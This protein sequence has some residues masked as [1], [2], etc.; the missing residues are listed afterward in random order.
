MKSSKAPFDRARSQRRSFGPL[1]LGL[2]IVGVIAAIAIPLYLGYTRMMGAAAP[3]TAQQVAAAAPGS[4]SNVAVEVTSLSS[5]AVLIGNLLQKN[6]DGT[7]SRTGKMVSI[8]WNATKI[9][10]GSSADVKVG[11]VLQASGVLNANDVLIAD[12]IVILTGSVQLK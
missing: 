2:L 7:Y 9:V 5:Q 6:A 10:M 8:Q 12:Q 1:L 11:A 4:H 3:Q